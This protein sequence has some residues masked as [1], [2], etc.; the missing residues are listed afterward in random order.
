[1]LDSHSL[2]IETSDLCEQISDESRGYR[3]ELPDIR[4]LDI[5]ISDPYEQISDES[6]GYFSE[7]PDICTLDIEFVYC[8]VMLFSK[9][10]KLEYAY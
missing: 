1:M 9:S 8:W 7:L 5:E 10:S 4:T 3:S 6:Q 2:D